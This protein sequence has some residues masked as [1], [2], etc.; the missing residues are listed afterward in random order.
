MAANVRK[1][2]TDV[3]ARASPFFRPKASESAKKGS[4]EKT[5]FLELD[6]DWLSKGEI[7]SQ[8][9][10][11]KPDS[12]PAGYKEAYLECSRVGVAGQQICFMLV[13]PISSHHR[14][15]AK[16]GLRYFLVLPLHSWYLK[17]LRFITNI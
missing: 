3:P 14:G 17:Q 4:N 8:S 6:C 11:V 15:R 16:R 13:F 1:R 7:S 9:A 12:S 5:Q 2:S 10:A